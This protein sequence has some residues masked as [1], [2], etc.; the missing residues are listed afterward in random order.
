MP[1]RTSKNSTRTNGMLKLAAHDVLNTYPQA[2]TISDICVR[3]MSLVGQ[4]TQKMS[5]VLNELVEMG[6]VRKAK[7]KSK[8]RMVYM[9]TCHL[10]EATDLEDQEFEETYDEDEDE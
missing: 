7:S 5:R 8:K 3:D 2:M 9:A 1:G 10:D 6:L 4:T